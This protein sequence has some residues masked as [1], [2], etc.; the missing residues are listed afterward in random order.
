[1]RCGRWPSNTIE[2]LD[3]LLAR[4]EK[5]EAALESAGEPGP[6]EDDYDGLLPPPLVSATHCLY[7]IEPKSSDTGRCYACGGSRSG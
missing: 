5:A 2:R 3:A 1:M 7:Y 4:A 6:I